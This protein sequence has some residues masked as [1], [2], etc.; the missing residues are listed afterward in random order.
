MNGKTTQVNPATENVPHN[1]NEA[2]V[3]PVEVIVNGKSVQCTVDKLGRFKP[4]PPKATYKDIET[5]GIIVSKNGIEYEVVKVK[6]TKGDEEYYI[7]SIRQC[8]VSKKK[9]GGTNRYTIKMMA[10]PMDKK[11]LSKVAEFIEQLSEEAS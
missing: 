7:A 6:V 4:V 11:T 5:K 3:R 1:G 8:S 9:D 2:R 10:I